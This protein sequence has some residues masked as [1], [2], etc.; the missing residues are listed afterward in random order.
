MSQTEQQ[1]ELQSIQQNYFQACAQ[2]GELYYSK[3]NIESNI[4]TVQAKIGNIMVDY[5][6]LEKKIQKEKAEADLQALEQ[7]NSEQPNT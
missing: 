7:P 2:L 6:K 3:F 4:A 1:K 5:K